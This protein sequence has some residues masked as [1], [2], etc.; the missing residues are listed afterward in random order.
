VKKLALAAMAA[1]MTTGA[2][3]AGFRL[4]EQG[5]AAHGM[6]NAFVAAAD[7]ASAVWYNPAAMVDLE[8]TNVSLG[9]VMIAPLTAHRNTESNGSAKDRTAGKLNIPPHFYA[10][11]R[12]TG[13]W[14]LGLGMNMPFGLGTGWDNITAKTR[15][16]AT[17]SMIRTVNTNL[18]AA[19]KLD[20]KISFGLGLDHYTLSAE[21]DKWLADAEQFMKGEGT[22]LG[23][24]AAALYK[25]T[26]KLQFGA[27]YRSGV[28]INVKG[29][30]DHRLIGGYY[31][32]ANTRMH[33]PDTFQIGASY[34]Y[35][36]KWLFSAEADYTNWA[37]YH[38]LVI[39]WKNDTVT[40]TEQKSWN[41]VWAYRLGTQYKYSDALKL[42]GGFFYDNTPVGD[43]HFET[44]TPDSDRVALSLGAGWDR[45]SFTI[46][47]SYMYLMF[48]D[49]TSIGSMGGGT[50]PAPASV[51][52]L[53]DG[54]YS[55]SAHLPALTVSYKF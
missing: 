37:T 2:Y 29:S 7:D 6:G 19:Y 35:G 23:Y 11:H 34:K 27:S 45:G 51:N 46:D 9:S 42:R 8:K 3:S 17:Y 21:I 41:S 18:N 39:K 43:R 32:D 16:V 15:S 10:A 1:F 4:T 38:K 31:N 33:L 49:R 20:D 22:G 26:E 48:R 28:K 24:N 12:L 5:A 36:G 30:I 55:A 25:H 40:A 47:A 52:H 54:N 13:K 50:D 44:R 14:A 53:L